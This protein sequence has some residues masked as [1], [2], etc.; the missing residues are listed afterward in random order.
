V[1]GLGRVYSWV[2]VHQA[3]LP[4]F[5]EA[6]PYVV[7]A[8]E[9]DEQVGLRLIARMIGCEPSEVRAD[10][11][12]RVEFEHLENGV[13]LPVFCPDPAGPPRGRD[14]HCAEKAR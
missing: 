10:M 8:I 4:G 9:L 6:V 14:G 3:S 1:S 13:A 11:R 5:A 2:V 7:A 12:V